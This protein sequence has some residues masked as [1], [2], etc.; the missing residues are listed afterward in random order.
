MRLKTRG[1]GAEERAGAASLLAQIS[2]TCRLSQLAGLALQP[3][4]KGSGSHHTNIKTA[5]AS[6]IGI[7][8]VVSEAH[9]DTFFS[10]P[11]PT[12]T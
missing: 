3:V 2:Q 1:Y 8:L 11:F 7:I 4:C 6:I 12:T 9:S 5:A 10:L